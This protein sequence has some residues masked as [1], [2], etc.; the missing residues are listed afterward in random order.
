MA[1]GQ[2]ASAEREL[3]WHYGNM[4]GSG[5]ARALLDTVVSIASGTGRF[6]NAIGR[7]E[8]LNIGGV[9]TCVGTIAY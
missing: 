7:Q 5:N 4:S 8:C 6:A 3:A 9:S 1:L 2:L